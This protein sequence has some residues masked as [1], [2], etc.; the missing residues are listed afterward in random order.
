MSEEAGILTC[1]PIGI[2]HSPYKDRAGTPIQGN[3]DEEAEGSIEIFPEFAEGLA[4]VDG[5]SYIWVLYHFH[6]SEGYRLKVV[7]FMDTVERGLFSTRAPRRPNPIGLSLIRVLGVENNIIKISGI[8]MLDGT[9]VLDI[10]PYSPRFDERDDV[11]CGWLD[12]ID[13][14]TR[15]KRSRADGRFSD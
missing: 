4:D 11:K 13:E 14:D 6:K 3:F 1:R 12:D 10:K 9:P 5:F 15:K 2:V 7:P 8:D